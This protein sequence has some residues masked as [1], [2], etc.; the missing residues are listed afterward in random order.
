MGVGRAVDVRRLLFG[1]VDVRILLFGAVDVR[2]L[3]PDE[4]LFRS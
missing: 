2:I 1:A 3:P 4:H